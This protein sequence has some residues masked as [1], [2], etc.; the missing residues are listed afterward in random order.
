MFTGVRRPYWLVFLGVI[1]VVDCILC[2]G[3]RLEYF[4]YLT[5]HDSCLSLDQVSSE[6]D[7]LGI[8]PTFHV[9]LTVGAL[10]RNPRKR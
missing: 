7:Q 6:L 3:A 1:E 2:T 9:L 5:S 10:A 8:T 4:Q